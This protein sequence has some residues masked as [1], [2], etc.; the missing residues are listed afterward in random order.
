M[1]QDLREMF[2]DNK[3]EEFHLKSGHEARFT[4]FLDKEI[5]KTKIK[6]FF[7]LKIA[8]SVLVLVS[9]GTFLLDKNNNSPIVTTIVDK[10]NVE[11]NTISLGDLSP[12]LKKV[13][14]YYVVNINMELSQLEVS[15]ENNAIVNSFMDQLGELNEE[16]IKLNTEL[17]E[18]GP[19]DQTISALIKNLQ[20]RLE[21]LQKLKSKLNELKSSKNEQNTTNII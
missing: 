17:N 5:P 7:W 18:I 16:Y 8:A 19:N 9:L 11:E 12:D 13:E 6:S 14:N 20:L 2:K 1:A 3:K 21:L 10:G 4:R 15:E